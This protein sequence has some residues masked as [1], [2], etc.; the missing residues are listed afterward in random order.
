[1]GFVAA[2][3]ALI[4]TSFP[5]W[6]LTGKD[7]SVSLLF[8]MLGIYFYYRYAES[9]PHN[10]KYKYVAFAMVGLEVWVRAEA[11]VPL[12]CALILTELLFVYRSNTAR[13]QLQ[14][15][16]KIGAVI[17]ISL[18]PFF[19]NNYLLFGNIFFPPMK[20]TADVIVTGKI[21]E[22]APFLHQIVERLILI[23][24]SIS[25]IPDAFEN[26]FGNYHLLPKNMVAFILHN[27][28]PTLMSIVEVCPILI[29][30]LLMLYRLFVVL[31]RNARAILDKERY[32]PFLFLCIIIVHILIY[33][34]QT[35]IDYRLGHWDYRYFMPVYIPLLY[36]AISALREYGVLD[37]D[38]VKEVVTALASCI[39]ILTPALIVGVCVFGTITGN[40]DFY[41][42]C[43]M[44]KIIAWIAIAFLVV[45][46]GFLA[47]K[48]SE[49]SKELFAYATGFSIFSSFFWLFSIGFMWGKAPCAGFVLPVMNYI[50]GLIAYHAGLKFFMDT[51]MPFVPLS[52]QI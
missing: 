47:L 7:H 36:F 1:M 17:L 21:D 45:S 51:V 2:L 52:T 9:N 14:N 3:I 39:V 48:R 18:L 6:A 4:G 28:D 50:H 8:I 31:R 10:N 29:F 26:M 33:S 22:T 44:C 32:L 43:I 20:A 5:L 42:L 15:I 38:K 46:F 30:A 37:K 27:D 41:T 13:A 25:R 19:I 12:F 40:N 23:V 24:E 11:A 35:G 34:G 16:A 49:R